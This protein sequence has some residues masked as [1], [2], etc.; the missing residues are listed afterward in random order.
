MSEPN[1]VSECVKN[2]L[3]DPEPEEW[4]AIRTRQVDFLKTYGE[5]DGTV[6][7]GFWVGVSP[8]GLLTGFYFCKE[9]GTEIRAAVGSE[10][11][12]LMIK[13]ICLATHIAAERAKMAFRTEGAA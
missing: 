1:E 8:D 9:D 7:T 13:S 11:M 10:L 6:C 3:K 5:F 12:P 2:V 4:P